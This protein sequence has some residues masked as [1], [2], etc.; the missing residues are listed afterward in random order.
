MAVV[1]TAFGRPGPHI[2]AEVGDYAA[3][4]VANDSIVAGESVADAQAELVV[5]LTQRVSVAGDLGGVPE[6]PAV[7]GIQGRLVQDIEPNDGDA[8]CWS[9]ANNRWEPRPT[10][11]SAGTLWDI[12]Y[13]KDLRLLDTQVI[14][15]TPTSLE[16]HYTVVTASDGVQ[17]ALH[18]ATASAK[19][20]YGVGIRVWV[21]QQQQPAAFNAYGGARLTVLCDTLPGWNPA[22]RTAVQVRV[23]GII[24]P[25]CEFGATSYGGA[26]WGYGPGL[27]NASVRV[28]RTPSTNL[29]QVNWVSLSRAEPTVLERGKLVDEDADRWVLA[30]VADPSTAPVRR[31]GF[32]Y[33][34]SEL[35][36]GWPALEDM[37]PVSSAIEGVAGTPF[38]VG[39]Y[40]GT[41]NGSIP[42][43]AWAATHIRI[44]QR[45]F[46]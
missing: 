36:D 11:L 37:H 13:D 26:G 6:A 25:G 14:D 43:A 31:E 18:G 22:R 24:Q 29:I 44:L 32:Y 10:S 15:G 17:W 19:I 30:M 2:T 33:D 8:L 40:A 41:A 5:Q 12:I 45:D 39:F 35:E 23:A 3:S 16:Q 27:N 42:T 9:A 1:S 46:G 21:Q 28:R 34:G 7:L 20:E 4:Q 38:H